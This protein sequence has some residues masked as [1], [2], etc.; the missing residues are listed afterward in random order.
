MFFSKRVKV[1]KICPVCL[2]EFEGDP[3]AK[4]CSNACRE[5]LYR[6]RKASR[7]VVEKIRGRA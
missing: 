3:Q 6:Q 2:K 5:A 4:T 7:L 1:K